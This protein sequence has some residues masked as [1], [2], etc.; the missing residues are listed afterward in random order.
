GQMFFAT[1]YHPILRETI[2]KAIYANTPIDIGYAFSNTVASYPLQLLNKQAFALSS[3]DISMYHC[4]VTSKCMIPIKP[5]SSKHVIRQCHFLWCK[6]K[7]ILFIIL[8]LTVLMSLGYL[9]YY[10]QRSRYYNEKVDYSTCRIDE[11]YEQMI[12]NLKSE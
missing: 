6:K 12:C 3:E 10:F 2:E 11:V 7:E 1:P 5:T 8:L 9:V 4:G